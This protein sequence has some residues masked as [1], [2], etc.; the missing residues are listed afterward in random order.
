M[1]APRDY[2]LAGWFTG[3]AM[4]G[5]DGRRSSRATSTPSRA[6][7]CSTGCGTW[8]AAT[9]SGCGGPTAAGSA[10]RSPAP[11]ATPRPSS[12][13]RPSSGRSRPGPAP[14]HLQRLRPVERPLPGQ[15]GRHGNPNGL[16]VTH[17]SEDDNAVFLQAGRDLPRQARQAKDR[18]LE[19]PQTPSGSC[20]RGSWRPG[21]AP[22]FERTERWGTTM[23][24]ARD[25]PSIQ[26]DVPGPDPARAPPSKAAAGG[27]RLSGAAGGVYLAKQGPRRGAPLPPR[28]GHAWSTFGPHA[29]G[30]QRFPTVSNGPSGTSFAQ[31]TAAILGKQALG[32]TLI[33]MRALVQVQPGPLYRP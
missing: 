12:P 5:E 28:A 32:R 4:P 33:R 23:A 11:L 20:Q 10:S 7:R 14:D 25:S 26:G 16:E 21:R 27:A 6:R 9:P 13:P 17:P 29:I 18:V 8:A 19:L 3:G 1:E 31:A 2:G 22:R 30:V 15:R 24:L